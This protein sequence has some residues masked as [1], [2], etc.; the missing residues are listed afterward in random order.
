[1]TVDFSIRARTPTHAL[2]QATGQ[3]PQTT[4]GSYTTSGVLTLNHDRTILFNFGLSP[5]HLQDL[6]CLTTVFDFITQSETQTTCKGYNLTTSSS[7]FG[8]WISRFSE[9]MRLARETNFSDTH[10]VIYVIDMPSSSELLDCQKI[11]EAENPL[12]KADV[13]LILRINE[14]NCIKRDHDNAPFKRCRMIPSMFDTKHIF[15]KFE[16]IETTFAC[17]YSYVFGSYKR[18]M[19]KQG[20]WPST[21]QLPDWAETSTTLHKFVHM[22]ANIHGVTIG[23][24]SNTVKFNI[25]LDLDDNWA[26]SLIVAIKMDEEGPVFVDTKDEKPDDEIRT[27]L[28]QQ[29]LDWN[30]AVDL[31]EPTFIMMNR[32]STYTKAFQECCDLAA[33]YHICITEGKERWNSAANM[34]ELQQQTGMPPPPPRLLP[35]RTQSQHPTHSMWPICE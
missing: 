2:L 1:M 33:M 8:S 28:L 20:I 25:Q 14:V 27:D 23:S 10:N 6:P 9:M 30:T 32:R 18:P 29:V 5:I 19:L 24:N 11:V 15:T 16:E 22:S 31:I 17:I 34:T 35:A 4:T 13:Y 21:I 3:S 12:E 26:L 7:K